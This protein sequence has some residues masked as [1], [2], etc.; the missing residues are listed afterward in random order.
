MTTAAD[1]Q[2]QAPADAERPTLAAAPGLTLLAG[3]E[4]TDAGLCIGGFCRLPGAT[5]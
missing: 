3:D 1:P 4:A 2:S 5:D